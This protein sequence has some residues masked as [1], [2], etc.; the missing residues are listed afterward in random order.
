[1]DQLTRYQ[2][3]EGHFAALNVGGSRIFPNPW[4]GNTYYVSSTTGLSTGDALTPDTAISTLQAAIDLAAAATQ[5]DIG[6]TIYLM[7]NHAETIT[8][9]AGLLFDVAGLSVIGLGHYNQ[10]ARFLMDGGTTVTASIT[11]A[12]VHI[13]NVVFASGHASVVACFTITG[14]GAWFDE[15]EWTDNTTSESFVTP[16]KATGAANTADGLMVTDCRWVP[17]ISSVDAQEFIEITDDIRDLK[18][19]RNLIVHE[20]TASPLVLQA[21]TKVMTRV[22]IAWNTVSHKMTAGDLMFDNGASANSG[23][24]HHNFCRSADTDAQVNGAVGGCGFWDNFLA[25]ASTVSGAIE[26][27]AETPLT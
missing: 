6:A 8:G 16:L 13:R 5:D 10:R 14:K 18:V 23:V 21:G 20:G 15:C 9:V 12:D 3:M 19:L 24:I 7:P 4:T 26:P 22:E 27:A 2:N 1:M 11:A 17:L 25:G